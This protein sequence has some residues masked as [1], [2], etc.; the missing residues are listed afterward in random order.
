MARTVQNNPPR[1]RPR[2]IQPHRSRESG[3]GSPR[4]AGRHG[5]RTPRGSDAFDRRQS[6]E[7]D[8]TPSSDRGSL[9]NAQL[10]AIEQGLRTPRTRQ[11]GARRARA[12]YRDIISQELHAH[13]NQA[14]SSD[15]DS[16][17]DAEP[18]SRRSTR[19]ART[20]AA[21]DLRRRESIPGA[22]DPSEHALFDRAHD[23]FMAKIDS[24]VRAN[25]NDSIRALRNIIEEVMQRS[26]TG[27]GLVPEDIALLMGRG[28][29]ATAAMALTGALPT[30]CTRGGDSCGLRLFEECNMTPNQGRRQIVLWR[31]FEAC[32]EL[33]DTNDHE[34]LA[35]EIAAWVPAL[36]KHIDEDTQPGSKPL[37][38]VLGEVFYAVREIKGALL[39]SVMHAA[40]ESLD[41]DSQAETSPSP[42][43]ASG[44]R[45]TFALLELDPA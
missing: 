20:Y 45:A 34:K 9:E 31:V 35:I 10:A 22:R 19:R 32:R 7:Q 30:L 15:A 39:T 21:F 1:S 2:D 8:A 16:D 28:V 18:S 38:R 11:G 4:I 29:Y 43:V 12:M 25:M 17:T 6:R 3:G 41:R 36:I 24:D 26:D 37:Q 40:S 44:L 5:G 42:P 33:C 23:E 13:Q 27:P 14:Q